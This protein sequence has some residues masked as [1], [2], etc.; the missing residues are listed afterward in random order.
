MASLT[1]SRSPDCTASCRSAAE[2]RAASATSVTMMAATDL[3][4]V[5]HLFFELHSETLAHPRLQFLNQ[6]AEFAGG[7][8]AG[9]VDQVGVIGRHVNIAAHNALR[10]HLF[11]KPGHGHLAR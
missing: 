1:R 4:H 9:I 7:A 2:S 10:A 6:R 5:L 8:G 3:A 11:Q